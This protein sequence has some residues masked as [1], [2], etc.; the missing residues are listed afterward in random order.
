MFTIT[1]N[2]GT[3]INVEPLKIPMKNKIQIAAVYISVKYS[4]LFFILS[5]IAVIFSLFNKIPS[6][7]FE[8]IVM[9]SSIIIIFSTC[10]FNTRDDYFY[11]NT[12][13]ILGVRD[14]DDNTL[15]YFRGKSL[16]ISTFIGSMFL[17]FFSS[18]SINHCL[19]IRGVKTYMNGHIVPGFKI[20][21]MFEKNTYKVVHR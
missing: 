20:V 8:L 4:V 17:V 16:W 11:K 14:E 19:T 3:L 18:M 6:N 12:M 10:Y 13:R 15:I 21:N 7:N 9:L 5:V 2:C 1:I